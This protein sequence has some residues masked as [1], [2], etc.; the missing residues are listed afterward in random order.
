MRWDL[1]WVVREG[2]VVEETL[3][4]WGAG[5][6]PGDISGRGLWWWGPL[7]AQRATFRKILLLGGRE[8]TGVEVRRPV[9]TTT[10]AQ[11]EIPVH[12]TWVPWCRQHPSFPQ[13]LKQKNNKYRTQLRGQNAGVITGKGGRGTLAYVHDHSQTSWSSLTTRR[14]WDTQFKETARPA[15]PCRLP[16]APP[17]PTEPA[18]GERGTLTRAPVFPSS[19]CRG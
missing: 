3:V 9:G 5:P 4:E 18:R 7:R 12:V 13:G 17:Q 15:R 2:C 14:L 19:K 1:G 6:G 10:G 8:W 16:G 11:A